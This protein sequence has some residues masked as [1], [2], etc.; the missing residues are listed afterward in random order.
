MGIGYGIERQVS[1]RSRRLTTAPLACGS[2]KKLSINVTTAPRAHS[3]DLYET[4]ER[5]SWRQVHPVPPEFTYS[6]FTL[7]IGVPISAVSPLIAV[8]SASAERTSR[9]D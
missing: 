5:T 9:A 8:L 3:G 1:V 4:V 6:Q 7:P 2:A